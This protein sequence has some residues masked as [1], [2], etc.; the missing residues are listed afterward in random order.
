MHHEWLLR[1][2]SAAKHREKEQEYTKVYKCAQGLK[3][4]TQCDKRTYVMC[5]AVLRIYHMKSL[6]VPNNSGQKIKLI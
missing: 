4:G 3:G 5:V 1:V 2:D 6:V